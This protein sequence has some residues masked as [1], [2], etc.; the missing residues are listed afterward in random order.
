VEI[1]GGGC[2]YLSGFSGWTKGVFGKGNGV[3]ADEKTCGRDYQEL[4]G[5]VGGGR[6]RVRCVS[7]FFHG[8]WLP[9]QDSEPYVT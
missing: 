2:F 6:T 3:F 8:W 5:A 7:H 4:Q 1:R 9:C